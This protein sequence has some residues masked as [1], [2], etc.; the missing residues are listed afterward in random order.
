MG[1]ATRTELLEER[2]FANYL[3]LELIFNECAHSG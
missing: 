1:G 2:K 3:S